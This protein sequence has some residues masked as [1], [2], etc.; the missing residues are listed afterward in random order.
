MA[1][2]QAGGAS[3]PA[4]LRQAQGH[5]LVGLSVCKP[6][7]SLPAVEFAPRAVA[8]PPTNT[9]APLLPCRSKLADLQPKFEGGNCPDAQAL[10]DFHNQ[11]RARYG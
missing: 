1:Q 10:L 3:A 2:R 9:T 7:R 5:L 6:L 8:P 4:C 11:L